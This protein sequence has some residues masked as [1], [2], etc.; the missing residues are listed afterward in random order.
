MKPHSLLYLH[1]I[2]MMNQVIEK[3]E[4]K[5]L[6]KSTGYVVGYGLGFYNSVSANRGKVKR[7]R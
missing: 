4:K 1:D 2:I 5:Y 6:N 7:S 3:Q